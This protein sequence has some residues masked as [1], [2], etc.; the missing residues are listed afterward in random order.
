MANSSLHP[1][2]AMIQDF[3][4]RA[5]EAQLNHVGDIDH[6]KYCKHNEFVEH[7]RKFSPEQI[8]QQTKDLLATPR[9]PTM[10]PCL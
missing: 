2:P 7:F 4:R 9:E 1:T 6:E 3:K 10:N 8:A 5:A